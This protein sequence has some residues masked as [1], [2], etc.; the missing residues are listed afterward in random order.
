MSSSR[1]SKPVSTL[2]AGDWR[3]LLTRRLSR[4]GRRHQNS[5]AS[6]E[7]R[8]NHETDLCRRACSGCVRRCSQRSTSSSAAAPP[9]PSAK[10]I[11]K[12]VQD[13]AIKTAIAEVRDKL[14]DPYSE[15]FS[16]VKAFDVEGALVICGYVNAKNGFGGYIG[17]TPFYVDRGEK[18][19]TD[20]KLND[21]PHVIDGEYDLDMGSWERLCG[22]DKPTRKF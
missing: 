10:K 22:T 17:K 4:S 13:D 21:H 20:A 6:S 12:H 14:R 1:S 8:G 3:A 18:Y 15:K 19:Y 16:D 9:K 2:L 7:N 5:I 11:A